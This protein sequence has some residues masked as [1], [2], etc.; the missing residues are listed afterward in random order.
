MGAVAIVLAI[1]SAVAVSLA[2]DSLWLQARIFDTDSVVAAA[3]PLPKDPIVSTAVAVAA[4]EAMSES[5]LEEQ[6]QGAL[7]EEIEFLAPSFTDFAADLVFEATKSLVESD[8]FTAVWVVMVTDTHARA[9]ADLEG[10]AAPTEG[11][12]LDLDEAADAIVQE[13]AGYGVVLGGGLETSLG[14]IVLIQAETLVGPG[15]VIDVFQ[16]GLWVFPL[17][18]GVMLAAAVLIDPKRARSVQIWGFAVAVMML[19]SAA[20][21]TLARSATIEGVDTAV[22]QAAVAVMWDALAIGYIPLAA[23]IAAL[24]LIVGITTWWYRRQESASTSKG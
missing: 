8:A 15:R 7:P 9:M 5:D 12:S 18:A 16:T 24:G 13:L 22:N 2:I 3:A 11:V 21:L 6:I 1:L 4:A 17:L 10:T 14:K 23:A 19:L 20:G